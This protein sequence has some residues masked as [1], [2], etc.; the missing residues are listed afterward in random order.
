MKGV[1]RSASG[2][3]TRLACSFRRLAEMF[4]R[5]NASHGEAIGEAPIAAREARALPGT[6]PSLT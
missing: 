2:E 5:P 1:A 6:E 3:R 4:F